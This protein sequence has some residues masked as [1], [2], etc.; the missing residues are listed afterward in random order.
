V[1]NQIM[2]NPRLIDLSG[3]T[4]GRW[5]VTK[6]A[7]NAKGGGALWACICECGSEKKVIGGD[8]RNGK[9][10]NCGCVHKNRL[11]AF[12][13]THGK[14]NTRL[15]RIWKN[16]RARCLRKS[17]P[18]YPDWGG[19][20]IKICEEWESFDSF[21]SWAIS[22]G[23]DDRLSI[24]R[25]NVNG[26]YDPDNCKW[27]TAKEQ[28]VNRRFVLK[29]PNGTPWCEIA[30]ENGVPVTLMHGRIHDG[31]PVELAATTPRGARRNTNKKPGRGTL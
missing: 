19:R 28:S 8:L 18:Q 21:Y 9:S 26:D 6:Q 13:K 24:E 15:H 2:K 5:S 30:K 12:A 1:Y 7:G 4:F 25:I 29:A 31:W 27:A 3:M 16:M 20:G 11:G 17:S 10:T 23:Y 22:S 14:S